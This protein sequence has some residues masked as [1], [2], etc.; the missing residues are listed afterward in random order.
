MEK[1]TPPYPLNRFPNTLACDLAREIVYLLATRMVPSLEGS[2]WE[3]IFSRL[4]NGR[5]KPSNVGL[6]DIVLEQTAWS[7]KTVKNASPAKAKKVRLI[8][9]R[10]SPSFSFGQD[11]I[12]SHDTNAIGAMVLSIWNERVS[13]IRSKYHHLRTTVLI[14]S[15]DL[16]ELALFEHDTLLYDPNAFRWQWNQNKN[17]I[18][19]DSEGEHK[20]T[21][22]PHGSQFTIIEHV[23]D[24][25]LA[26]VIQQPGRLSK[27]AVLNELGFTYDWVKI[28]GKR[29][30]L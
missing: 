8:S 10:N 7:A 4:I 22:Q 25:R 1:Y 23:P 19:I 5:W 26:I 12:F 11:A 30:E 17:L 27:E 16:L 29:S 24:D 6:D 3:Q 21:W 2:D 20:F 28:L 18:G 15:E 13:A 9:G 14:K